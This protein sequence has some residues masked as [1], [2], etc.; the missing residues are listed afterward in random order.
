MPIKMIPKSFLGVDI[1]TSAIKVVEISR[2]GNRR[3]LENYGEINAKVIYQKPFRTFDKSTLTVSSEDTARAILAVLEE[4]NIKTKEVIFSIPDFSSFFTWFELP[5]MTKEEL[6]QAVEYE[7]RQHIP[8]PLSDVTLDWQL[9]GNKSPNKKDNPFKILLVAVPNEVISQYQEIAS[10]AQLKLKSLEAEVFGLVRAISNK[11]H[12]ETVILVDIG[13]Q[14]TTI[15]IIDK[16][17]LKI[18]HSF[19]VAGNELT[20]VLSKGLSIDYKAAEDQKKSQGLLVSEKPVRK[21]LLPLVDLII[22]EIKTISKNY[23]E[24]GG[25]ESQKVIL[26]GGT[27]LLSGLSNYF[28]EQLKKPVEIINPFS[29]I[30]YPPILEETLKKMGPSYAIAVGVALRGLE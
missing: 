4:S 30:F 6:G 20:A 21:I 12:K 27:A 28:S 13:S 17:V 22:N 9:I 7:A 23:Q 10:M 29:D 5:S 11:D 26:A 24:S 3:K 18:S 25:G 14:S 15:S 16:K 1:G 19:D 8:L 2:W